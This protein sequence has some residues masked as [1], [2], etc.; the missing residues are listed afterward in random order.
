M[1]CAEEFV[2]EA[3][4]FVEEVNFYVEVKEPLFAKLKN[5]KNYMFSLVKKS[6]PQDDVFN[7]S[8]KD[9]DGWVSISNVRPDEPVTEAGT[10]D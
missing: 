4:E 6:P 10:G 2:E 1:S 9:Q 8:E 3:E 5:L 7:H